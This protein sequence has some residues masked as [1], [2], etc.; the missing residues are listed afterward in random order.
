M[1]FSSIFK[2]TGVGC[3]SL[4][5][6]IFSTQRLN[7]RLL[8]WQVESLPLSQLGNPWSLGYKSKVS[9]HLPKCVF[10]ML[11]KRALLGR[12][13]QRGMWQLSPSLSP[14]HNTV[15]SPIQ[16]LKPGKSSSSP[17]CPFPSYPVHYISKSGGFLRQRDLKSLSH[18]SPSKS[19]SSLIQLQR[20][21]S[22]YFFC[23]L[24]N[25]K[26]IKKKKNFH[27]NMH[28]KPMQPTPII[29]SNKQGKDHF[30]IPEAPYLLHFSPY[31]PRT[32]TILT[33]KST[34]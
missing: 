31:S 33:S 29:F 10:I 15:P 13:V 32:T 28:Q 20:S 7:L 23:N 8:H 22:R 26:Q 34:G 12:G 5:Q 21:L 9:V 19:A 17:P 27:W 6:G 24:K 1:G 30:S 14:L 18:G 25:N 3:H 16:S 2:N 4:L 11:C